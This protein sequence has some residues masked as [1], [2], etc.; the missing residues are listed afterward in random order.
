M[1]TDL[2]EIKVLVSSPGDVVQERELIENV[3]D[4][5]NKTLGERENISLRHLKY[6]SD[7]HPAFGESAQAEINRQIGD[8]DIFLGIMW[9]RFGTKTDNAGSG[10]EEEFNIAMKRK[11]SGD[12]IELMF[13]FKNEPIAPSK[14]DTTQ[15]QKVQDFR[16]KMATE[17][18][19][20]YREFI[21]AD[22]FQSQARIHLNRVVNQWLNNNSSNPVT[23]K[24]DELELEQEIDTN[25]PLANLNAVLDSPEELDEGIFELAEEGTEALNKVTSSLVNMTD[26]ANL[27]SDRFAKRTEEANS[28]TAGDDSAGKKVINSSAEDLDEFV[29]NMAAEILE[30]QKNYDTFTDSFS[31]LALIASEDLQQNKADL[32]KGIDSISYYR[33]SMDV[34]QVSISDFRGT[35]FRLPRLT[36]R[37]NR[38]KRKATA[39]TDDLLNMMEQSI[40]QLVEI[41]L[42]LERIIEDA[43][44]T[45]TRDVIEGSVVEDDQV[46]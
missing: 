8:Y 27:L 26:C 31:K 14:I 30:H 6:E 29:Q 46:H 33:N 21:T 18:R 24:H 1:P 15:L 22:E 3:I 28:V 44:I 42:L 35:L 40:N 11:A 9:G 19:G 17:H 4:E 32:Q 37:F 7:T 38:S 13:Y 23:N 25:A 34:A 41:E 16:E 5:I 20:Y 2:T 39:V 10:T 43:D 45:E 12:L 36:G